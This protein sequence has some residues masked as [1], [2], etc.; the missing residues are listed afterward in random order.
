MKTKVLCALAL[1]LV[2]FHGTSFDMQAPIAT[3]GTNQEQVV[4]LPGIS[5]VYVTP[6]PSIG[7]ADFRGS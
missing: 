6:Q 2:G 5:A 7:I 3:M 1:A 4:T